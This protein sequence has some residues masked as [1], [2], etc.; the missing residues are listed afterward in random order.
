[1]PRSP[2]PSF[3]HP[4]DLPAPH[5]APQSPSPYTNPALGS[6]CR[7]ELP[8]PPSLCSAGILPLR[9]TPATERR[10]Q[11]SA[12]R[13]G[14]SPALFP[15]P[16]STPTRKFRSD[17]VAGEF[18]P[19]RNSHAAGDPWNSLTPVLLRRATTNRA[20]GTRSQRCNP[21]TPSTSTA[22]PSPPDIAVAPSAC[23]FCLSQA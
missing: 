14:T 20:T 10:C 8:A 23:R 16:Y 13:P 9:R 2:V 12:W 22:P 5:L 4:R 7:A 3:K 19:C 11:S 1:M 6:L 18:F 21:A 17:A 15:A